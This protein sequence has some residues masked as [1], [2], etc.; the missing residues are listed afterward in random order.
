MFFESAKKFSLDPLSVDKVHLM[1]KNNEIYV[2][3]FPNRLRVLPGTLR[4][5]GDSFEHVILNKYKNLIDL[6]LWKE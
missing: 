2:Y 6:E 1:V 5:Y 4:K 3:G